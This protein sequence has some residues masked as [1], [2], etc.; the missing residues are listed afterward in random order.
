LTNFKVTMAGQDITKYVNEKTIHLTNNLGQGPGVQQNSSGRAATSEFDSSL[1]PSAT[2]LGAGQNIPATNYLTKN[3]SDIESGTD[4]FVWAVGGGGTV[5]QDNTTAWQGMSSLKVVTD[6]SFGFQYVVCNLPASQFEPGLEYTLSVYMKSTA[7]VAV[8]LFFQADLGLPDN[9]SIGSVLTANL[10]TGWQRFTVTATMPNPIPYSTIGI[11]MDTGSLATGITL[12]MD[13]LQIEQNTIATA[14]QDGGEQPALVRMGETKIYDFTGTLVFGGYAGIIEDKTDRKSVFTHVQCYDYWQQLDRIIVTEVYS[15]TSDTFMI[16][17]LISKYAPWLDTSLVPSSTNYLFSSQPYLHVTLQA[18]L[19]SITDTA[20]QVIWITPD[21]KV[22]YIPL[23]GAS[24]AAFE[25]SDSPNFSTSY[26]ATI[27]KYEQDDTAAINRVYFY[28]GN[29]L[30]NDFTQDISTQANGSNTLF[31]IAYYPYEATDG[32]VHVTVGGVAQAVAFTGADQS[33]LSNVLKPAGTADVLINRSSHTLQFATAP[34]SGVS[35]TCKYRYQLP[36]T[37]VLTSQASFAFFG[38]Y[39]D[40]TYTDT[41]VIETSTAIQQSRVLLS[42]QAFGLTTLEMDIWQ[43]GL[44]PGT[45]ITVNNTV[46]GISGNF[47]IQSVEGTFMGGGQSGTI[48]YHVVCGAWHW[49]VVDVL[50]SMLRGGAPLDTNI[51]G[52]GNPIQVP[53]VPIDTV[54]VTFTITTSTRTQG[55]YYPR[56]TPVGD[57]HDAYPGLASV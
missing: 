42:E 14:W 28:G 26:P 19:Q 15:G 39:L 24:S 4:G 51:D 57:G 23:N 53:D 5:T 25:V 6:G 22:H 36:L 7:N 56:L 33:I 55:G 48:K 21:K 1:G 12:W 54:D 41:T 47:M 29:Y 32:H 27:T 10:T 34:G 3:Q 18:A 44:V 38:Q 11:R 43:P 8:R 35:V 9:T 49:N 37:V 16:K 52:S 13:G 50:M 17:D 45:V 30:S 20:G 2:A 31:A 40:G 46:R